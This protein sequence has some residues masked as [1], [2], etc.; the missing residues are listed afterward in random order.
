MDEEAV[1]PRV[2]GCLT[3]DVLLIMSNVHCEFKLEEIKFKIA[4]ALVV[5]T[6]FDL[7]PSIYD[8]GH[9]DTLLLL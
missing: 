6:T 8:I 9:I 2:I 7:V 5:Y 1:K 4:A 3:A